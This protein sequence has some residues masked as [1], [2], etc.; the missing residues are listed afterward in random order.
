MENA[1]DDS[2]CEQ[3]LVEGS[4][5]LEKI[6]AA[7]KVPYDDL[8]ELNPALIRNVTPPSPSHQIR[9]PVGK[10]NSLLAGIREL[11][12]MESQQHL[13]HVVNKGESLTKILKQYGLKKTQ[14]AHLNPDVNFQHKLK[15]GS[16]LVVPTQKTQ[17]KEQPRRR[18]GAFPGSNHPD[19]QAP[20]WAPI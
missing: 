1:D 13:V 14:L 18:A 12:P 17:S 9:V 3:V 11:Q 7:I 6:A 5:P 10:K 2:K 20:S 4:Y 16:K 15:P 8:L 19:L